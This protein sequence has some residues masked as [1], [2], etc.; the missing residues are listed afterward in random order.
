MTYTRTRKMLLDCIDVDLG[1]NHC[2]ENRRRCSLRRRGQS[3]TR[4]RMVCDLA[5]RLGFLPHE[6]DSL[7]L[8]AGRSARAQGSGVRR[9]R[10]DLAPCRNSSGRRDPRLY[11]GI[12]RPPKT[13]LNNVEPGE[14]KIHR[15]KSKL[16]STS[17]AKCK[18][19]DVYWLINRLLG[20]NWS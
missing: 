3:T 4:D 20:V 2:N 14:V 18:E 6:P 1:V 7:R 10:L 17:R 12:S 8:V 15:G 11:L 9:R 16:L 5:Q 13:P 19:L